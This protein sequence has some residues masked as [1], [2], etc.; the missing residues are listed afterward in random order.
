MKEQRLEAAR[1][2]KTSVIV[3]QPTQNC[4][5]TDLLEKEVQDP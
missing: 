5:N 2:S 1:P 3:Y 4:I